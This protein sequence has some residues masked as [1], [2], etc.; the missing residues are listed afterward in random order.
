MSDDLVITLDKVRKRWE[1]IPLGWYKPSVTTEG[2]P[3]VTQ[4]REDKSIVVATVNPRLGAEMA[5]D[6]SVFL[7]NAHRDI[8]F[9]LSQIK[10]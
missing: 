3:C 2:T 9:L 5:R 1:A 4:I 10:E 7:A 6:L 8:E